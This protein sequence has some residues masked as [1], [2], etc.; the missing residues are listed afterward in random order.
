MKKYFGLL[1]IIAFVVDI[2]F[3]ML[4]LNKQ[5]RV[6][7]LIESTSEVARINREQQDKLRELRHNL[8]TERGMFIEQMVK[9]GCLK[10]TPELQEFLNQYYNLQNGKEQI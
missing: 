6:Y 4:V 7:T 2:T 5:D 1:L 3:Y 10:M 8:I 9:S